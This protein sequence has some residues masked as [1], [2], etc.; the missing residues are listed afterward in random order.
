MPSIPLDKHPTSLWLKRFECWPYT[1]CSQLLWTRADLEHR[2]SSCSWVFASNFHL[3]ETLRTSYPPEPELIE[4][5]GPQFPILFELTKSRGS[6]KAQSPC[7]HIKKQNLLD[8]KRF[9]EKAKTIT[10]TLF[11]RLTLSFHPSYVETEKQTPQ[12]GNQNTSCSSNI[13]TISGYWTSWWTWR[14]CTYTL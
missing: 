7:I 10:F 6:E 1:P 14:N 13:C 11:S 4:C 12:M 2:R 9:S 3:G 8:A 5:S